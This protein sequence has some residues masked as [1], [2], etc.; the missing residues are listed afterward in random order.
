MKMKRSDVVLII[1]ECLVEPHFDDITKEASH[2]LKRLED[3]GMLPPKV[4]AYKFLRGD[5]TDFLNTWELEDEKEYC[6]AV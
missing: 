1:E 4:S 6:G 3:L 2:I 5:E